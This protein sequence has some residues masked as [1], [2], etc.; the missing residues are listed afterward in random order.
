MA[1]THTAKILAHLKSGRTITPNEA[2][3]LYGCGRLAARICELRQRGR[4][5][6]TDMIEVECADGR[7]ARVAQYRLEAAHG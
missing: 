7:N 1:E 6:K 4:R 5:I 3:G 2:L